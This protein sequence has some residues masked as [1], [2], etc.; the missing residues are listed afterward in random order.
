M[1]PELADPTG[2]TKTYS[3][4][5]VS[6][7]GISGTA[8][9]AELEDGSTLLTLELSGTTSGNMHPAHIHM[10]TAAEG[11]DIAVS[12]NAVDGRSGMSETIIETIDDGTS[13][14]YEQL[15]DYDGYINVHLSSDDLATLVAQ[16]DI[17]QNE[18]TGESTRYSLMEKDVEGAMGTVTFEERMNG[19]TLATI[20]LQGTPEGIMHPAHIHDNSAEE[21]GP[22]AV[23]FSPVDGDSGMSIT[24]I[25]SKDGADGSSL[26]YQD[27]ISYDGYVNVHFSA[28]DLATLVAQGDIG[29]NASPVN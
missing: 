20:M 15:L 14:S 1:M 13:I 27:I 29:S 11:G 26:S 6:D 22:I 8:T 21:G 23:T 7:P 18:L 24:N 4:A 5:S 19:N 3:L 10:N 28:D 17:G 2:D 12:L 9:L 25:S 16:G